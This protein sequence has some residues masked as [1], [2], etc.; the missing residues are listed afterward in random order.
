[1]R[2]ILTRGDTHTPTPVG[3]DWNSI[4]AN[5]L[6]DPDPY[7]E[8]PWCDELVHQVHLS[9]DQR[10]NP[11]TWVADRRPARILTA[12][13]LT[14]PAT[15]FPCGVT[16]TTGHHHSD[17][18]PPRRIDRILTNRAAESHVIGYQVHDTP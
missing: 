16:P 5:P 15:A 7:T 17:P 18:F 3:A 10:G 6:T 1:M 8:Q 4:G 2:R 12:G 13:G 11:K 14:D 9:T